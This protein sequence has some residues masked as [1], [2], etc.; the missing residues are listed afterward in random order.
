MTPVTE[1]QFNGCQHRQPV[2]DPAPRARDGRC[3][4]RRDRPTP[5]ATCCNWAAPR[6][7]FTLM[8]ICACSCGSAP[9]S[10]DR[11]PTV[12]SSRL[13]QSRFLRSKMSPK[14]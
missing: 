7:T 5:C 10:D 3:L 11:M 9:A 12:A 14:R 13:C 6:P 8:R 4:H 1:K 2:V